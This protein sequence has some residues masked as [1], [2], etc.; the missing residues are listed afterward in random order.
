[1]TLLWPIWSVDFEASS[2]A[3][4]SYPIEIG[5]VRWSGPHTHIEGWSTLIRPTDEWLGDRIWSAES[6]AVHGIKLEDLSGGMDPTSVVATVNRIVEPGTVLHC[7][8]GQYDARW[9]RVLTAASAVEP[10]WRL[11]D[12]D[13]LVWRLTGYQQMAVVR[14]LDKSTAKHRARDDAERL[15]QAI[16][17][18]LGE[19]AELAD[20][21]VPQ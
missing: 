11:G 5:I 7:D 6:A 1:M 8:G 4:A 3:A 20:L 12:L 10:W 18:G 13:H 19:R 15:M 16:A 2:L 21:H 9:L 14:Y 17:R